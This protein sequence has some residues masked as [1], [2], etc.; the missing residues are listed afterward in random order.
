MHRF[1]ISRHQVHFRVE[2]RP[3]ILLQVR[4]KEPKSALADILAVSVTTNAHQAVDDVPRSEE[5]VNPFKPIDDTLVAVNWKKGIS[6]A[7]NIQQRTRRNQRGYSRPGPL[8]SVVQEHA[9]AVAVDSLVRD[10]RG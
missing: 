9:I 10:V 5:A 1:A 7:V 6:V 3:R 2:D 8:I 4:V